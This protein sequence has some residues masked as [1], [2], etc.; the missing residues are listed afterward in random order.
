MQRALV[1]RSLNISNLPN[2]YTLAKP[3]IIQSN[4]LFNDS[5]L[6][7]ISNASVSE[8]ALKASSNCKLSDIPN[9]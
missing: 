3:V 5:K 6:A 7:K 1:E 8:N 2:S 9:N 4:L